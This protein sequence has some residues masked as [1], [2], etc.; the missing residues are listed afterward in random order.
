MDLKTTT[1]NTNVINGR[2]LIGGLGNDLQI[3]S[4]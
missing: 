4:S 1:R 3:L 2:F